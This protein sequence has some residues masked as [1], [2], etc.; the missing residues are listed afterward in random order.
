MDEKNQGNYQ[1][2]DWSPA[3]VTDEP[4]SKQRAFPIWIWGCGGGCLLVLALLMGAGFWAVNF[5]KKN[6]GPEAAWPVVAEVMPYEGEEPPVDYMATISGAG[7]VQA[8]QEKFGGDEEALDRLLLQEMVRLDRTEGDGFG[9]LSATVF[10]FKPGVE[11][12]D[13]IEHLRTQASELS[14]G[15]GEI[16]DTREVELEFQGR[17]ITATRFT[18]ILDLDDQMRE[19]NQPSQVLEIDV[20]DGRARPV[21]LHF[22]GPED[23]TVEELETFFAPFDVW[24]GQ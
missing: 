6:F 11:K 23:P 4:R 21:V 9:E 8:L 17:A 5:V 19:V 18:G 16:K 2:Q 13:R 15:G 7:I 12:G 10:V 14:A 24:G 1:D 22:K 3:M 20:S